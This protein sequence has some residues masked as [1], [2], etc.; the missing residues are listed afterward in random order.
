M[1]NFKPLISMTFSA[2]RPGV[3]TRL[4]RAMPSFSRARASDFSISTAPGYISPMMAKMSS[5][6]FSMPAVV[7]WTMK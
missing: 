5:L 4:I 2:S 3:T 6:K 7:I 1:R